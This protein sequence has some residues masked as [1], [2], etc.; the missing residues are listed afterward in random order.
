MV[1]SLGYCLVM[2]KKTQITLPSSYVDII[3]QMDQ[4]ISIP[5]IEEKIIADAID[6][7]EAKWG[8]IKYYYGHQF[9]NGVTTVP[10]RF[11]IKP[12]KRGFSYKTIERNKPH[13]MNSKTIREAHPES[14][15]QL[16]SIVLAPL[17][18]DENTTAIVSLLD[19]KDR[20]LSDCDNKLLTDFGIAY[21]RALNMAHKFA[22]EKRAAVNREKFMSFAAHEIKNP[23]MALSGYV[24]LIQRSMAK[25]KPVNEKWLDK[26][27]DEVVRM[28]SL[29]EELL[30]VKHSQ[31]GELSYAKEKISLR[32]LLDQVCDNFKVR[33]P[34]RTLKMRFKTLDKEMFIIGDEIKLTQVFINLL[35]NA[36]KF[37]EAGLDIKIT[38]SET[39]D[40]FEIAI[41]DQGIGIAVEEV[42]YIFNEF[43]RGTNGEAK[44]GLGVGLFLVHSIVKSHNGTIGVESVLG[45][46][47]TITVKLPKTQD[48]V[49]KS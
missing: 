38:I 17:R 7:F 33:N 22:A 14:N 44:A 13:L 43:Y 42:P 11:R 35:N 10:P 8:S 2:P 28:K 26:M 23:L 6:L 32:Q 18:M 1:I 27:S 36:H 15:P 39:D 37:S 12:R 29:I 21:G 48:N 5:D 3:D 49:T 19:T 24:Q 31:G 25:K 47:T 41:K 4:N 34:S 16:K 20:E 40:Y 46:G 45:E 30:S 9:V